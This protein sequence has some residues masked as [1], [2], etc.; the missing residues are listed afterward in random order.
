MAGV[1]KALVLLASAV[2]ALSGGIWL[3]QHLATQAKE[4][5][6]PVAAAVD[7][8]LADITGQA[9]SLAAHRGKLVLVNF[10]ATWCPPCR[11]EIP[12]LIELQAA[13]ADD[14]LQVLGIA[15][16]QADK[17]AT[18]VEQVGMNYP[19]IVA[20]P[21]QGFDLMDAYGAQVGGLPFN[22]LVNAAGQIVYRHEGALTRE[23]IAPVLARHL[24]PQAQQ[25][26]RSGA[27]QPG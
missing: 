12:L 6:A 5:A 24:Q 10:W 25:T 19:A 15:L 4:D 1:W 16:D 27:Q 23:Q 22:V 2:A 9:Q 26:T 20:P 7:F 8:A 3:Q 14:G 13:H 17:V 11:E 18:Y 21:A